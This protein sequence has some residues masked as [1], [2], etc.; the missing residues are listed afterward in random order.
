MANGEIAPHQL[1][2][3]TP[4]VASGAELSPNHEGEGLIVEPRIEVFGSRGSGADDLYRELRAFLSEKGL[5]DIEV[6]STRHTENIK[7]AFFGRGPKRADS[8]PAL[9]ASQSRSTSLV[10]RVGE[11]LLEIVGKGDDHDSSATVPA[12]QQL[13]PDTLPAGVIVLPEMRQTMFPGSNTK[14]SVATPVESISQLCKEND[15]PV[16]FVERID[17]KDEVANGVGPLLKQLGSGPS[18]S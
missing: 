16:V 9:E 7:D 14:S 11:R 6:N 2:L 13:K 15:V 4:N 5:P 10:R 1:H 3:T 12:P 8:K 17:T 18:Q